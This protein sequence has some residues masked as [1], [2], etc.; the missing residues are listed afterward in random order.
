MLDADQAEEGALRR[1]RPVASLRFILRFPLTR[2]R[3][4][5][6]C[7]IICTIICRRIGRQRWQTVSPSAR[8]TTSVRFSETPSMF[9]PLP[10]NTHFLFDCRYTPLREQWMEIYTPIVEQM[11][12]QIRFNPKRR[13]VEIKVRLFSSPNRGVFIPFFSRL[14]ASDL[15]HNCRSKCNSKGCGFYSCLYAWV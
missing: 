11:Q 1:V 13:C 10:M 3:S 15:A 12:L 7:T 5:G 6:H 4:Q 2:R 14:G 9:D 8:A